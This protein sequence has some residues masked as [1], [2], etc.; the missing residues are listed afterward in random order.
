MENKQPTMMDVIK[1]FFTP[2]DSGR[3]LDNTDLSFTVDSSSIGLGTAKALFWV[4][5]A[6]LLLTL[7]ARL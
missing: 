3:T 7:L 4:M 5:N 2:E 6:G 1:Y